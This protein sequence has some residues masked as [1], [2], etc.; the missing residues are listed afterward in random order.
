MTP[1]LAVIRLHARIVS[2][3]QPTGFKRCD[4]GNLDGV[5]SDSRWSLTLSA[6]GD[7]DQFVFEV[8]ALN[9]DLLPHA[10]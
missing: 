4:V 7:D 9:G 1:A 10:S 3:V 6:D 8:E 5:E 2:G